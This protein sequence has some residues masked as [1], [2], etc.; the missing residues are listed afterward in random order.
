MHNLGNA[1]TGCDS[2]HTHAMLYRLNIIGGKETIFVLVAHIFYFDIMQRTPG[3]RHVER[4]TGMLSMDMYF[5]NILYNC[6]NHG[7]AHALQSLADSLLINISILD[8]KFGAI[9]IFQIKR[10]AL[11]NLY[12][13]TRC[14]RQHFAIL[15]AQACQTALE[16]DNQSLAAGIN[17]TG[18]LQCRQQLRSSCKLFLAAAD[19]LQQH[20]LQAYITAY[21]IICT[22]GHTTGYCQNSAFYRFGYTAVSI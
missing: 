17:N 15:T 14:Y 20:F 19:S 7:I 21:C 18:C 22:L 6:H 2:K 10:L 4:I 11:L 5:Y 12:L 1:V 16:K 3:L 9:R 13:G 8:D